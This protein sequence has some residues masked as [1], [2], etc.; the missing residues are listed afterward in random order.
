MT[1]AE[2]AAAFP[3]ST[4]EAHP[5]GHHRHLLAAITAAHRLGGVDRWDLPADLAGYLA[6][7]E[8]WVAIQLHAESTGFTFAPCT[9]CGELTLRKRGATPVGCRLTPGCSGK[10][11]TK[12]TA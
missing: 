5:A 7:R 3:G 10:H 11:T 1:P 6:E 9:E 8:E 12:V 2:V 4:W